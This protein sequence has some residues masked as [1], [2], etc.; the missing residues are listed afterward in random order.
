[1]RL[2]RVFGGAAIDPRLARDVSR[3]ELIADQSAR[4]R[5]RLGSDRHTVGP[6][7]SDQPYRLAGNVDA[8]IKALGNLHC[9]ARRETELA[10]CFLLQG[11]GGERRERVAANLAAVD[12]ADGEV[13]GMQDGSGGGARLGLGVEI[14]AVEALAVEMCQPRGEGLT[15]L[16]PKLDLDRPVLARL[17][18]LNLGFPLTDQAQCDGLDAPSRAA[19]WQL[20]PQHRR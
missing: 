9:A 17:E 13:R 15:R 11:R 1:M 16:S 4:R 20:A 12:F 5:N 10:R 14:E 6:H 3:S 8:F 2:L 19:A 7:I 18:R